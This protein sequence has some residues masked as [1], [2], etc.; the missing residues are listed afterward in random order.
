VTR[1]RGKEQY[2]NMPHIVRG[3]TNYDLIIRIKGIGSGTEVGPSSVNLPESSRPRTEMHH[4]IVAL[5]LPSDKENFPD[6][7]SMISLC[8]KLALKLIG[9][10]SSGT[11]HESK[12]YYYR[13]SKSLAVADN[14]QFMLSGLEPRQDRVLRFQRGRF[15]W[16]LFDEWQSKLG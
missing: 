12:G 7:S 9:R 13:S 16:R 6:V 3:V 14:R 8:S 5:K 4:P 10:S 1:K 11:S 15:P 2:T